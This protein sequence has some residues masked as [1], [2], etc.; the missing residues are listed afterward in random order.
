[1]K[2][3]IWDSELLDAEHPIYWIS[4]LSWLKSEDFN[5]ENKPCEQLRRDKRE[6]FWVVALQKGYDVILAV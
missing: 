2:L 5:Q 6:C 4:V 1:M 3:H